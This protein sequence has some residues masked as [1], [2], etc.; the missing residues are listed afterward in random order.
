MRHVCAARYQ[1]YQKDPVCVSRDVCVSDDNKIA[2]TNGAETCVRTP[3]GAGEDTCCEE[4]TCRGSADDLWLDH[5]WPSP[6]AAR[7]IERV[8]RLIAGYD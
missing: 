8:L 5:F 1:R 3:S 7:T 2:I 4:N 6:V